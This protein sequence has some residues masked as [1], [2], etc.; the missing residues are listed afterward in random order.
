MLSSF[1]SMA[2]LDNI[3]MSCFHSYELHLNIPLAIGKSHYGKDPQIPHIERLE[4]SL[5]GT[6]SFI[7]KNLWKTL[8]QRWSINRRDSAWLNY[9]VFRLLKIYVQVLNSITLHSNLEEFLCKSMCACQE[10]N[11]KATSDSSKFSY[12]LRDEQR[13]SLGEFVDGP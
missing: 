6:L 3:C 4:R 13:V 5:L 8:E 11:I 1:G 12:L 10:R 7:L 2:R 9:F